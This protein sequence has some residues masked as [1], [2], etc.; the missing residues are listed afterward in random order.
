M[1]PGDVFVTN[2]PWM[3]TGHLHDFT[4]LT[5]AFLDG[6]PVALF[7]DTVHVVDIGGLGFGA[8]GR[9]VVE[10]PMEEPFYERPFHD[11]ASDVYRFNEP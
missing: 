11:A 6:R 2:D 3:G 9:Q 5:P 1:K 8:D 7:A 4:V 10:V